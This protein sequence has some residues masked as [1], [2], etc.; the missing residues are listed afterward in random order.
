MST[1][2]FIAITKDEMT[3]ESIYCHS[4]GYDSGSGVGPTLREH[5]DSE[6]KVEDLIALG[7]LSYVNAEK[8]Y[9]YHRDRGDDWG[10]VKPMITSSKRELLILALESDAEYVYLFKKGEWHSFDLYN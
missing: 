2:C 9:A 3:Y 10:T 7:Y 6:S 5:Y 1:R 4:D 8:V